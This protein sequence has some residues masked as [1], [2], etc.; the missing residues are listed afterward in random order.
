M[1]WSMKS[2]FDRGLRYNDWVVTPYWSASFSLFLSVDQGLQRTQ[3][4]VDKWSHLVETLK[5]PGWYHMHRLELARDCDPILEDPN[6][7][8]IGGLNSGL[9]YPGS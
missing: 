7:T 1:A 2:R 8:M 3:I 6:C 5:L 9:A 4:D